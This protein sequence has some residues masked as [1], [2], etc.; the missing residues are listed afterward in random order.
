MV[1]FMGILEGKRQGKRAGFGIQFYFPYPPWCLDSNAAES[2]A[3]F[4]S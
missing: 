3:Y 2:S 4:G 1:L